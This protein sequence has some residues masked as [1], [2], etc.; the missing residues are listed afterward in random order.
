MKQVIFI[1]LIIALSIAQ[2]MNAQ[3]TITGKIT[4]DNGQALPGATI[5]VKGTTIG[6][7][8]DINGEY[9]L[10]VPDSATVLIFS[11][12]G[13][14]TDQVKIKGR[15]VINVSLDNENCAIDEVVV[16]AYGVRREKKALGYSVQ[17]VDVSGSSRHNNYRRNITN[18]RKKSNKNKNNKNSISS[19]ISNMLQIRGN[20]SLNG[21]VAGVQI[22]SS[23]G[24][25]KIKSKTPLRDENP[26]NESYTR[27]NENEFKLVKASPLSTFSID[28]DRASYSNVRRFINNG[29][30]PPQ[31]AVRV[32]EMI[33]YFN[34]DYPNPEQEHPIAVINEIAECPWKPKHKLLHIGIQARKIAT[35]ELPPSNLVFLIDVSGSMSSANKL[36]LLK[37]AFK[38]LT[39]NLRESDRVAIVVYAGAAGV[40][41]PSTY[42]INKQKIIEALSKLE[43]GGSTAGGAGINLAYKI[44]QQN[45]VQSGNNRVILATDGDFNV[46][47]SSNSE[48]EKLIKEK[49][50]SG[51]YLTCLGFG[52][53]NYKDSKMETLADK[54][55]GNYAYIDN[56][57][58][59]QKVL[60]NEFGGTLYTVAKDVKLQIEFNPKKVQAYRLVGYENR[61]LADED[62]NNDAKD[63]GE[64]GAG[65]TVTALYEIIPV[66]VK[67]QFIS[68]VDD[69]KYQKVKASDNGQYAD[70]LANVKI[71]YKK[72]DKMKSV[73]FVVPIKDNELALRSTSDNFRFSA[74][75]ALFGLLLRESKFVSESNY[76]QVISLANNSKG[77]DTDG[78]RTEFVRLV[79]AV[80]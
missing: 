59:A 41:L 26:N 11:F 67:S 71:R 17:S 18:N 8:S 64:I 49:K 46:G 43:S 76:Q 48:M 21:K 12:I 52:M 30:K 6:I 73:K 34:Y 29:Q 58:E 31:D 56:I 16:M 15:S 25:I 70:E 47:A 62:F 74:S 61:L 54:G 4:D 55:N 69:L 44:A 37:N 39:N 68:S 24:F 14:K 10:N 42:G 2:S 57:Q 1:L 38:L 40:V 27:I 23:K 3:I 79:K 75:V 77:K 35:D 50:E 22:T 65:H 80:Q 45:F 20:S 5:V 36:P 19:D 60:V 9:S 28:V 53:G 51:I 13:M 32:E 72:P 33:N 7:I 66:G 78:Y 63:A